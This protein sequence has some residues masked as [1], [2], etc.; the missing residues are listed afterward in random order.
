MH[1]LMGGPAESWQAVLSA[2]ARDN[3]S[4]GRPSRVGKHLQQ[5]MLSATLLFNLMLAGCLD[6]TG[7]DS[8]H[9][10][11]RFSVVCPAAYPNCREITETEAY[12]FDE[13]LA[14]VYNCPWV[15]DYIFDLFL[16]NPPQISIV[17]DM[18]YTGWY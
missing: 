18:E 13:A 3:D 6:S 9:V 1:C 12:L 14:E 15:Q 17:A 2:E 16:A 11:A 7:V 10:T 8:R 4:A 5:S